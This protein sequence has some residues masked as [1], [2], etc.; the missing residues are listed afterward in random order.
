MMGPISMLASFPLSVT[1]NQPDG[2]SDRNLPIH[3]LRFCW[4][5][6]YVTY[7]IREEFYQVRKQPGMLENYNRYL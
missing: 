5:L 7:W 4:I 2:F 6:G 1:Q 3:R